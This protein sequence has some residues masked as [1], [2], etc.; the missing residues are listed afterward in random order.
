MLGMSFYYRIIY[1]VLFLL[2]TKPAFSQE[3]QW[4]SK[5]LGYSSEYRPGRYGQA[6][7]AKQILGEPSKL[8][9]FGNSPCA[10]SP[11]E[12]NGKNEEWIKV[13]F[14]KPISLKQVAIAENYNPGAVYKVFAYTESGKEH[15][16]LDESAAPLT[17]RGRM[18]RVF[19]KQEGIMANAIKIVLQPSRVS[20]FNQID[21]IGIS[22]SAAPIEAKINL[23]ENLPKDV[24]KE[25]L[26]KTVNSTG[27][28]LA[29]II[30]PDGKTLYFTR[31]NF[32]GNIGS[33]AKQDVWLSTLNPNNTWKQP[34]NIGPPVNNAGDNAITS[35]SSDGKTIYLINVYNPDGTMVNGLSRS[36]YTKN[37]W[38]FPKEYKIANHYND[39]EH[40][41]LAVSPHGN[42][43][44][45]SVQRRDTEGHKDLYVSFIKKDDTWSEPIRMGNVINTASYEGSPFLAL[46]NKTLYF[47]SSGHSG[48][49]EGDL[50]VTK[51]LDDTWVNWSKPQNLGP[52]VNTP[53]WDGYFNIPASGDFA[54][55]SSSENAIGNE[56]IFRIRL[57]PE[58]KP[59]PVAVITGTIYDAVGNKPVRSDIV[60]DLKKNGD[61]FTKVNY[62]PETGEYR[63]ILPLKDIYRI[64]ASQDGYFPVTEELDLSLETGFKNIRK[65]LYLQPIKAGQQIRLSNTMFA[66]SS[67]DVVAASLPE[68]DHIV[69][70]LKEYPTMEILLEGH[71][72]NQGDMQKN[73]KLSEDRVLRVKEYL[74]SKGIDNRRIQTKAWGPAKPI[75]SNLTES[76]RQKN[77]RVEF[78]ILKI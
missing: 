24:K 43:L 59:D 33:P 70:T 62:D 15:L 21:A 47:T 14:D 29:P 17:V 27:Q 51:R 41:E 64:T 2:I 28:E 50:F 32:P 19:P 34:V 6:F 72:D 60:A 65:N 75:A 37:G 42:V 18:M 35:I 23:A 71:T 10:W 57:T 11:A 12:A 13:G 67:A 4:A 61:V 22:S 25:N 26:G 77:R 58:M 78:T 7:R 30:S 39:H 46:D 40:T 8:P 31:S 76:N 63:L 54:Y 73:V 66:Q 48:Y 74:V 69:H 38:S 3:L 49:G 16:L 53:Q 52:A 44:I 45:L 5:I 68:L 20:G 9:D 36:F 56:D 55:F 1:G